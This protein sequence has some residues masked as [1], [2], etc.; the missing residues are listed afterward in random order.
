MANKLKGIDGFW[1]EKTRL[2]Q[3]ASKINVW[4]YYGVTNITVADFFMNPSWVH[5]KGTNLWVADYE[6]FVMLIKQWVSNGMTKD[7]ALDLFFEASK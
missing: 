5:W 6:L 7:E 2:E 4:S 1:F 3:P